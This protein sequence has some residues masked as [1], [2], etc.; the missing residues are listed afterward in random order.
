MEIFW[1]GLS[2]QLAGDSPLHQS[3][4]SKLPLPVEPK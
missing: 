2:G 4:V 3:R 1:T